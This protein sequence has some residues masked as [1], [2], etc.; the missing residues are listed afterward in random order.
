MEK[1]SSVMHDDVQDPFTGETYSSEDVEGAVAFLPE[2]STDMVETT[3]AGA[4]SRKDRDV[5]GEGIERLG[6]E[7]DHRIVSA[8]I[9]DVRNV[10][11][12]TSDEEHRIVREIEEAERKARISLF[13]LPEAVNELSEIGLKLEEQTISV[14][15]VTDAID[16][17]DCTRT[18]REKLRSR[19]VCR[20]HTLK[21][22]HGKRNEIA[23]A[24]SRTR[25]Q[26]STELA[27]QLGLVEKEFKE[28]LLDL[29]LTNKIVVRIIRKTR[30]RIK[31]MNG[32]GGGI[33]V[34]K[35]RKLDRIESELRVARS[36]LVETNLRLVINVARK[37]LNRGLSFP[38]LIQEG[39]V[40]LMKA[41]ERFDYRKGYRFSTYSIW[42][43]RQA[44]TRAIACLG[45]TV[46]IPF[47][48]LELRSKINKAAAYLVQ[49]FGEEPNLEEISLQAGLPLEKIR[50][51]MK[52]PFG[53]VSIETPIGDGETRLGDLIEDHAVPSPFAELVGVSLK[54]EVDRVLSTLTSREEKVIRMRLGI[55]EGTESTLEE[56]GDLFGLTRERVRQIE[57][58]ALGKLR[59]PSRRRRLESFQE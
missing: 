28:V 36:R 14:A 23:R 45:P 44:I 25:M 3:W 16:E 11:V 39:N 12:L 51:T 31:G 18:I 20:I 33:T 57:T 50:R 54:E 42:W 58:K 43:I 30:Q 53:S 37:Y 47:H 9:E 24:L 29:T 34:R 52:A 13:E 48:V 41:A 17:M 35:L 46:R 56:V 49:E 27:G 21:G 38:D 19:T 22:L 32:A 7:P 2:S 40:G 26:D 10:P 8:Y 4:G 15:D 5:Q 55:G 59:H 6:P 1:N